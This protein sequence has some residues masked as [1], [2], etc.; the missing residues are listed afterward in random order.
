MQ[1]WKTLTGTQKLHNSSS[2]SI[3]GGDSINS[4]GGGGSSGGGG[5]KCLHLIYIIWA[6]P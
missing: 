4:G 6:P 5:S 3:G 1:I 2:S